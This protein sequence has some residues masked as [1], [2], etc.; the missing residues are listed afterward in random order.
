[1]TEVLRVLVRLCVHVM[2]GEREADVVRV[3]VGLDV[4]EAVGVTDSE[5]VGDGENDEEQVR[6]G[7]RLSVTV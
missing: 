2:D 4:G 3:G 1:M 5:S 7:V 6:V